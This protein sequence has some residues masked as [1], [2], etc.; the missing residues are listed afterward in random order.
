MFGSILISVVTL[1]HIYLFWRT[2]GVPFIQRHV[3]RKLLIA[4]GV[5]LWSGFSLGRVYGHHG[6]GILATAIEFFGMNWMA[7]SFLL[8]VSL[9]AVDLA[10]GF[11]LFFRR[12]VGSLRGWALVAGGLLSV[13]ALVQGL[14]PPV[15]QQYDV[16]LSGLPAEMDGTTLVAMSDLHI[17]SLFGQRWVA[18]RVAQV[19][20]RQPDLV[21][22]LGDIFEGHG[23][24][25]KEI[26]AILGRLRAPLGV[27]A[28]PGNHES[29]GDRNESLDL[30]QKAGIRVLENRWAQVRPGLVLAGVED[31][32]TL[33]R[34]Q[35]SGNLMGP[36]LSGRPPGA[37]VLLSHTPWQARE[38]ADAGAGLMLSGHTHGGQIWP[39]SYLI[40]LRYPMLAG[41]YQIGPMT[42]IVCRGTGTWGPRM[43]LWRPGEILSITLGVKE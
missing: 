9:F 39:F 25:E 38:A 1:M 27:W 20:A 42:A 12:Q 21:V 33:R 2:A 7:V 26:I 30:L 29:H 23:P 36:A 22:L 16:R 35:R 43:R 37:A 34:A 4:T 5:V 8:C 6:T 32:T 31:L 14:R 28:V 40:R 24:P 3:P 15:V 10:T 13:I 19:E 11:G 18:A 41:R 17:G